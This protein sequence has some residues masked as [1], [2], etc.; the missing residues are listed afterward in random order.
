MTRILGSR[1]HGD[2]AL[3]PDVTGDD[4]EFSPA[5]GLALRCTLPPQ[6]TAY[7]LRAVESPVADPPVAGP[8]DAGTLV[9][10]LHISVQLVAGPAWRLGQGTV[11]RLG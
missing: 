2:R 7:G 8:S 5:S 11:F 6:R 4:S 9:A 1:G 3:G 10:G